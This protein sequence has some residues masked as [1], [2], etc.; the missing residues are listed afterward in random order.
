MVFTLAFSDTYSSDKLISCTGS[1]SCSDSGGN[2]DFTCISQSLQFDDT[3]R[4]QTVLVA[5]S[6][7]DIPEG[8]EELTVSL[9][10]QD[11]E[12]ANSVNVA[13]AEATVRILDNDSKLLV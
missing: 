10:L 8:V 6:D 4:S 13:P 1:G 9:S 2:S 7:D 3:Q 5:I 12:L 11:M